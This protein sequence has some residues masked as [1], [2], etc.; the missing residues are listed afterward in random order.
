MLEW[1]LAF[2]LFFTAAEP[3]KIVKSS[4]PEP[5]PEVVVVH[6]PVEID[7]DVTRL[8]H[9]MVTSQ[10]MKDTLID[11]IFELKSLHIRRLEGRKK[12]TLNLEVFF[13]TH[14][15]V[16]QKVDL[17]FKLVDSSKAEESVFFTS[18][19]LRFDA[20]EDEKGR[21]KTRLVV[22]RADYDAWIGSDEPS[23]RLRVALK[24]DP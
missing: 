9:T 12:E 2:G 10:A 20:D 19:P 24:P 3:P 17:L 7:F 13:H 22:K 15:G 21:K 14:E 11:G 16:D 6:S 5:P 23:I 1:M 8:R 18:T 4:E